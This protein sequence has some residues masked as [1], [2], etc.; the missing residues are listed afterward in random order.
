[1]PQPVSQLPACSECG[2]EVLGTALFC[3]NCGARLE[4]KP[5]KKGS[6][7]ISKSE[8]APEAPDSTKPD[9]ELP[10]A[11]PAGDPFETA[12]E[13]EKAEDADVKAESSKKEVLAARV[14]KPPGDPMA[15]TASDLRQAEGLMR[16]RRI[17]TRW[18]PEDQSPNVWFLIGSLALVLLAVGI[19][20]LSLYLR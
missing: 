17:E 2:S 19:L 11:A 20:L 10:I 16:M 12:E 3:F 15:A 13:D 14:P 9:A 6:E 18:M 8:D 1:M 4:V 7:K 5:G